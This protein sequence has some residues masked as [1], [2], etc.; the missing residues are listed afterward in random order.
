MKYNQLEVITDVKYPS[1]RKAPLQ[2][3]NVKNIPQLVFF[4]EMYCGKKNLAKNANLQNHNL[5]LGETRIALH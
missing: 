4:L 1:T 3:L 5:I 2:K